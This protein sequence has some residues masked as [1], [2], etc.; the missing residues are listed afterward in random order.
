MNRRK[1][2][3]ALG[4]PDGEDN[5]QV[6]GVPGVNTDAS[7]DEGGHAFAQEWEEEEA[8][9]R[10]SRAPLLVGLAILAIIGWTGF[11]G[12]AMQRDMLAGGTPQ[13]WIGWIGDWVLP[14]LLVVGL[15]LLAMRNSTRE[16]ARFGDAA[17][18]LSTESAALEQRL[19]VVNR[20][21]SL[22]RDFVAAQSQDLESLGRVATERLSHNAAHLQQLILDNSVQLN[23]ISSVS[24]SA[25]ANMDRLRE[26]LP[27]ISNAARDVANKIGTA[28][29]TA[30]IQI[31]EMV[32]GFQRLND[33]GEASGRQVDALKLRVSEILDG[34]D[35]HL[36]Q[37]RTQGDGLTL[38]LS[39]GQEYARSRWEEAI[40]LLQ[41][42]MA[43]AISRISQ[44][45][46]AAIGNARKRMDALHDA[47]ARVD[48]SITQSAEAFELEMARR[49]QDA[50]E[51]EAAAF[52]AL[53]GRLANFDAE[54]R[55]RQQA[56]LDHL[57]Q[58][59]ERSDGLAQ[60]IAAFDADLSR[61]AGQGRQ[62]GAQLGETVEI[63]A[64]K[65]SQSRVIMEESGVFVSRL[66][67]D[68][69]RLLE[70]IRSSSDHSERD[71]S[72]SIARA[73]AR[74]SQFEARAVALR[75]TIAEAESRGGMLAEHVNS[76]T[77]QSAASLET[78]AAL[79]ARLATI[80]A[81]SSA[82]A[83]QAQDELQ[84]ALGQFELASTEVVGKLRADQADA[85]NEI[86]QS[87]GNDASTAIAA[88][89]REG[90][91]T[92]I[93]ELDEAARNAAERGREA[94]T[95]LRDQLSKVNQLAGN[96]E[97]R[98][99]Q[100]RARAEEQVNGDFS[101]RMALITES[102]NSSSID[103]A[104]ALDAEVTDTAW[105]SYLRGDR[106][107]FTRRAVRLLD[108]GEARA[109]SDVYQQDPEVREAINRYIHDFETM[110]RT[111]LST[112]DGNALAVTI[113]SSEIGK[114]YV[115]LAQ[116]IERLR[117]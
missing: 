3:V 16:A 77:G 27:V 63:L 8:L 45:D 55:E 53:Q 22:A 94:A 7:Q 41:A 18:S 48:Q 64:E 44:L 72:D 56:H 93:T 100:A 37:L 90:T 89:L 69:V 80:A 6:E 28:G 117:D 83:L 108:N 5:G 24:D 54:E 20:E 58:I 23:T 30:Q 49:R 10:R 107:I 95:Q 113:L 85:V 47:G 116:A 62:E 106:G 9:P 52:A 1:N 14:V 57:A 31:D 51:I 13:Q 105:A 103:I 39:E 11:F 86:A 4:S 79:E 17:R 68:S 74:L 19:S 110:L 78:L 59:A 109:V 61:L 15:W 34:F 26:Q 104:R 25:V 29:H 46:E 88:V 102:L 42:N 35:A 97:S 81:Q 2:L 43:E 36:A 96:L 84:S 114:L 71:L 112:R 99:T 38:T 73:E 12:W 111:I 40:Q 32:G 87:I 82:L 50:S 33:F 60:R 92:A 70:I 101:R 67:D 21:L 91:A 75:D 66:T 98:V 115:A 76:A 65:L